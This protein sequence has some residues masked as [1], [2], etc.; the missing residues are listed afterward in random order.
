MEPEF[1][2]SG[3]PNANVKSQRF[4][5]AISQI[6]TLPPVALIA[7]LNR[8]SQLETLRLDTQSTKLHWHL[9]F[10]DLNSQRFKSQRLQDTNAT[11]LQMLAF[12][13]SQRFSA[14]NPVRGWA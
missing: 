4:S 7:V 3:L 12:Y 10:S 6:A 11:K 5:Y 13:K 1:S 14:T 2:L 8:K 9:S